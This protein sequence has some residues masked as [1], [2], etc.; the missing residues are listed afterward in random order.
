MGARG[1]VQSR[2]NKRDGW[3]VGVIIRK[4]ARR[5]SHGEQRETARLKIC[6]T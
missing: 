1:V 4:K 5:P 2:E 3:G 6:H